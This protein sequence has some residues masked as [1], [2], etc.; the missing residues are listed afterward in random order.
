[1]SIAPE[2]SLSWILD[3]CKAVEGRSI[4]EGYTYLKGHVEA[5]WAGIRGDDDLETLRPKVVSVGAE[6]LAIVVLTGGS[7][8]SASCEALNEY[9]RAITIHPN[10]MRSRH[11]G[12]GVMLEEVD[13][14][15]LSIRDRQ[16]IDK[17]RE[18]ATQVCAMA[19]RFLVDVVGE[20]RYE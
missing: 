2:M 9:R 12:Y 18:E 20:G 5:L 16:G 17:V 3:G 7:I 13:E 19:V 15:W 4:R 6:A 8:L 14:L 11:E 1:M 10:P